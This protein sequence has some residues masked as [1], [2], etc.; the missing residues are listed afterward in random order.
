[1]DIFFLHF[2]KFEE[3]KIKISGKKVLNN[4][5]KGIGGQRYLLCS[6][7]SRI[8]GRD[9]FELFIFLYRDTLKKK[10]SYSRF[11]AKIC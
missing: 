2:L 4:K 8:A 3:K 6:V 7:Q 11:I 5:R 1:M 9:T 10:F